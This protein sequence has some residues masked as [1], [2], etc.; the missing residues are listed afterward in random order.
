L[1]KIGEGLF[2]ELGIDARD[3]PLKSWGNGQLLRQLSFALRA[4]VLEG[5]LGGMLQ[6]RRLRSRDVFVAGE[7]SKPRTMRI[8]AWTRDVD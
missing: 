3:G 4:P 1:S 8:G 6:E 7:L 2:D 5:R